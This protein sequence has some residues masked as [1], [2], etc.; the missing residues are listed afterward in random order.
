MRFEVPANRHGAALPSNVEAG[1][2]RLRHGMGSQVPLSI[3]L[4]VR[5]FN[6]IDIYICV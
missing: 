5:M 3:A 2:Q 4:G 1:D 6:D